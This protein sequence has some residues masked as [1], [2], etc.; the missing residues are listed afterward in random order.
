MKG[1][2]IAYWI[3]TVL[4][5]A[6]FS[7]SAV[8]YIGR[9]PKIMEGMHIL[10]YPEYML[11]ILATAKILGVL[12]LLTP[13]FPRL[14]E[15]AYAGFVIDIVGAFWSHMAMQGIGAAMGVVLPLVLLLTS[16][17]TFRILQKDPAT[18]IAK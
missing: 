5:A 1:T 4:T 12:A 10:G 14:K 15:W 18:A 6:L 2:K 7:M 17:I 8:M 16:Y 13:K 9:G 11:N 3:S